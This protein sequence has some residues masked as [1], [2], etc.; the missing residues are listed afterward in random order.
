P[1]AAGRAARIDY[2]DTNFP[3]RIGWK[4]V[5]VQSGSGARVTTSSAPSTS[6]SDELLAYP[7]NLLQSPLDV[8]SARLGVVAGSGP[9]TPPALRDRH[10]LDQRAGV[11]AVADGGFAALVSHNRL[12]VWFVLASLFVAFF[13]G[14]APALPARRRHLGRDHP[15]PDGA[16]R[17]SRRDLAAPCRLWARPH[18]R[19]QRRPR[20]RDDGHRDPRGQR[21]ARVPARRLRARPDPPAAGSE[22]TRRARFGPRDDDSRAAEGDVMFGLDGHLA[23]LSDGATVLVTIAVAILLGLRHA[24]DPDHLAAVTTLI[25]SGRE[26]TRRLAARLGLAWG[27]G[28]ATSLFA[29]GLPIVLFKA[30]LPARVQEAAETAVGALIVGLAVWLLVRWRRGAFHVHRHEHGEHEHA[31]AHA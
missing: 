6:I 15:V 10:V 2:R 12:T 16:R 5:V 19:L 29:F 27:F 30:Y 7:K 31:H 1:L 9:G 18:P 3:G 20:R 23:H 21:Q 14:A 22:R 8:S 26:R 25:A 13:W 24:T 4:E 11:R 17:P 28:H